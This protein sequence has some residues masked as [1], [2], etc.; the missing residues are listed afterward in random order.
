MKEKYHVYL[1][2]NS[3]TMMICIETEHPFPQLFHCC[4]HSQKRYAN[5][6]LIHGQLNPNCTL[7]LSK[8]EPNP[9]KLTVALEMNGCGR[10]RT[11]LTRTPF[12]YAPQFFFSGGFCVELYV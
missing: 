6:M 9:K 11:G 12:P 1:S 10:F 2:A 8:S 4:F 7:N 3:I 5:H